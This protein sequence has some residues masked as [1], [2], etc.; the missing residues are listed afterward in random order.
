MYFPLKLLLILM[1][2]I[3]STLE[4]IFSYHYILETNVG[5]TFHHY[6]FKSTSIDHL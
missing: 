5:E 4:P 3:P 1:H 6:S 2:I